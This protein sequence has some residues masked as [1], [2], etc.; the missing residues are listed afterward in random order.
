VL[1]G[2]RPAHCCNASLPRPGLPV[3]HKP[4]CCVRR[5]A[6]LPAGATLQLLLDQGVFAPV[7]LASFI[8]VLFTIE[9]R[10]VVEQGAGLT[11]LTC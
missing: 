11:R 9:V 6:C 10:A 5:V 4:H 8:A 2:H 1:L 3:L 7:F